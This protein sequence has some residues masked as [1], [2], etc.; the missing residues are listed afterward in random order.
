MAF[1]IRLSKEKVFFFRSVEYF[2]TAIII[3]F[4]AIFGLSIFS[5]LTNIKTLYDWISLFSGIICIFLL[6]LSLI[7]N[8][9]LHNWKIGCQIISI[10]LLSYSLISALITSCFYLIAVFLLV[11]S[12]MLHFV[13]LDIS[14]K[15]QT[16]FFVIAISLYLAICF[17]QNI[18]VIPIIYSEIENTNITLW[19]ILN[20]FF[21]I[22]YCMYLFI[23]TFILFRGK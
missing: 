4:C 10:S 14:L 13:N 18:K 17:L 15:N 5:N 6:I 1:K 11:L 9:L 2:Y 19:L 7:I 20:M 8:L 12:I 16:I 22:L 21:L 3:W 23:K